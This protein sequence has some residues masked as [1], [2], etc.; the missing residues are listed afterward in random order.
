[1]PF[2]RSYAER[3]KVP[4]GLW[5]TFRIYTPIYRRSRAC[6][7]FYC[8]ICTS[9]ER[10]RGHRNDCAKAPQIA[11]GSRNSIYQLSQ[12]MA[13]TPLP[14]SQICHRQPHDRQLKPSGNKA[15]KSRN[16]LNFN[17][18]CNSE[19][20]KPRHQKTPEFYNFEDSGKTCVSFLEV[21]APKHM[22]RIAQLMLKHRHL[23]NCLVFGSYCRKTGG[24]C[25]NSHLIADFSAIK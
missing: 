9:C 3:P 13:P 2:R 12:E 1:M 8:R 11:P 14:F 4:P 15:V 23:Y 7:Y 5:Q 18:F 10:I 6:L 19:M 22:R 24:F 25:Q 16:L 20:R 21:S 17:L